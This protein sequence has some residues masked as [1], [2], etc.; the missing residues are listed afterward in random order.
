MSHTTTITG[1]TIKDIPALRAAIEELK[2]KGVKC[3]LLENA[4]PRAYFDNQQGMGKADYVVKLHESRFDIGLY[5]NKDNE[6]EARTDLHA[7][8]VA[9][10]LGA[11]AGKG[12]D[13]RQ[14]AMGKMFQMYAVHAAT[15]KA[16][17]QGYKV[18]RVVKQDGTIQLRVAA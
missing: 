14:A 11:K 13:A 12:E 8:Q 18:Q 1:V 6:Y 7:N 10:V 15:R 3:D 2:S 9:N 16:M 5:K 17:Q 4:V